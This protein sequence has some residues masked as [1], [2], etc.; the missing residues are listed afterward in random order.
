MV[1]KFSLS[2]SFFVWDARQEFV[3]FTPDSEISTFLKVNKWAWMCC[4][5]NKKQQTLNKN[6]QGYAFKGEPRLRL[7]ISPATLLVLD[8]ETGNLR[9]TSSPP[10]PLQTSL[11]PY[12]SHSHF[13][14]DWLS[15]QEPGDTWIMAQKINHC[16]SHFL[17]RLSDD[18]FWREVSWLIESV[19]FSFNHLW[20]MRWNYVVNIWLLG[21]I[22]LSLWSR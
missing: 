16:S 18:H 13:S 8:G 3:I 15:L 20:K 17:Q 11:L 14:K 19:T 7:F 1:N 10:L 6:K 5:F 9:Y 2:L 22:S 4:C 12:A 21:G